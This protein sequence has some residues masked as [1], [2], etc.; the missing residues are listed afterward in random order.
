[1]CRKQDVWLHLEGN[2][3]SG[4]VLI[5]SQTKK[6]VPTG[7]SVALTL[8]SWIGVPAVPFVTLYRTTGGT[9]TAAQAAGLSTLNPSVRLNCL[10]LWCVLRSM[11]EAKVQERIES[12]FQV[13]EVL[14]NKLAEFP[15]LRVLSQRYRDL[16]SPFFTTF[17]RLIY[18]GNNNLFCNDRS[19]DQKFVPVSNLAKK[20]FDVSLCYR[21]V[22]PALA[23]QYVS[24]T[25][26]EEVAA[27]IRVP[28]YFNNLNSW[29]GQTMQR[30][31]AQVEN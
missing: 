18:I 12:V 7:D 30:D 28:A 2:A 21:T 26:P 6:P 11:G 20:D 15:S 19:A 14:N 16:D 23:F 9:E 25:P 27:G 10:P 8:G 5:P 13:L 3:L 22:N 24:D 17:F 31:C 4:L 1:M 29:L